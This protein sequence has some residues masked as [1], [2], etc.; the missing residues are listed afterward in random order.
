MI[1][2][3]S[4]GSCKKFFGFSDGPLTVA[5][6]RRWGDGVNSRLRVGF[7]ELSR[8]LITLSCLYQAMRHGESLLLHN[9][10]LRELHA[11]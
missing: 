1:K 7:V 10:F 9:C 6:G 4:I 11:Q 8:I 3:W 2:G 5:S